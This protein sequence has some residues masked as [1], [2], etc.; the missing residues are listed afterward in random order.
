VLDSPQVFI[1]HSAKE[2]ET[3]VFCCDLESHLIQREFRVLYDQNLET[4][5]AWRAVLDEWIWR[6]DGAVIV[7][8]AAALNSSYVPYEATL[9]RQRW[10]SSAGDFKLVV[11][12]TPG[13][14]ETSLPSNFLPVQLAEIQCTSLID[15]TPNT[16]TAKREEIVLELEKVRGREARHPIE[17]ELIQKFL[18]RADA[19][20]LRDLAKVYGAPVMPEGALRD[21][22]VALARH[23]LDVELVPGDER[24]DN[25]RSGLPLMRN[26]MMD[27]SDAQKVVKL[28]APFCW[29]DPEAA[30]Q[31]PKVTDD[32][33]NRRSFAWR[34]EWPLAERMY[35]YRTYCSQSVDTIRIATVTN[36]WGGDVNE[37]LGH[38]QSQ[39]AKAVAYPGAPDSIILER[40]KKLASKGVAVYLLLGCKALDTAIAEQIRSRWRDVCLFLFDEKLT[41]DS[42]KA[43]LPGVFYLTPELESDVERHARMQWID[44]LEE[45]GADRTDAE[46]DDIF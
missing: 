12:W 15:W 29:V 35:L 18:Y 40:L 41:R 39:L 17:R 31:L 20:G 32:E 38:V 45:A 11:V 26:V 3:M 21:Q 9:L 28:L 2:P 23:L 37:L 8:S 46:R 36:G 1:S 10:K 33:G 7:L 44:C 4:G 43:I 30:V 25:L 19:Q 34:R 22:A 16:M 5:Q 6:C 13:I 42:A 24:F 14:Y 27:G